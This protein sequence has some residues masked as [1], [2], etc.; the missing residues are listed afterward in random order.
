MGSQRHQGDGGLGAG[1][2]LVPEPGAGHRVLLEVAH[3]FGEPHDEFQ[4]LVGPVN[5]FARAEADVLVAGDQGP[6]AGGP[7]DHLAPEAVVVGVALLEAPAPGA[8]DADIHHLAEAVIVPD[9]EAVVALPVAVFLGR[10]EDNA[11]GDVGERHRTLLGLAGDRPVMRRQVGPRLGADAGV[12]VQAKE[13][14]LRPLAGE[15]DLETGVGL[16]NLRVADRQQLL[17]RVAVADK[18]HGHRPLAGQQHQRAAPLGDVFFQAFPAGP[19]QLIRRDVTQDD[20]VVIQQRVGI[21]RQREFGQA[22]AP[23]SLGIDDVQP[24]LV[25]DDAGRVHRL[26]ADQGG[27]QVVKLPA[28]LAIHQQHLRLVGGNRDDDG[29]GIVLGPG[30]LARV[31]G[32]GRFVL[33]GDGQCLGAGLLHAGGE[34]DESGAVGSVVGDLLDERSPFLGAG[35]VGVVQRDANLARGQV[36]DEHAGLDGRVGVLEHRGRRRADREHGEVGR[37]FAGAGADKVNRHAALAEF[38][39]LGA[40][41]GPPVV[42]AVGEDDDA[43]EFAVAAAALEGPQHRLFEVGEIPPRRRRVGRERLADRRPGPGDLG[44]RLGE[45]GDVEFMLR[46]DRRQQV[47]ARGVEDLRGDLPAGQRIDAGGDPVQA[48]RRCWRPAGLRL[49]DPAIQGGVVGQ[50]PDKAQAP[51]QFQFLGQAALG[52]GDVHAVGAVDRQQHLRG[53]RLAGGVGK[54]RLEAGDGQQGRDQREAQAEQNQGQSPGND[55]KFGAVEPQNEV[56]DEQQGNQQYAQLRAGG[57]IPE[58]GRQEQAGIG[59][60][61]FDAKHGR[62]ITPSF[63][64]DCTRGA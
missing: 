46:A 58:P 49:A 21:L 22:H 44:G 38:P 13:A 6:V 31:A 50:V 3:F 42:L 36:I 32:A 16:E 10:V 20:A 53:N 52:V 56:G 34:G 55:A 24:G 14:G 40:G 15:G 9:H 2:G 11:R 28:D 57:E 25:E 59:G 7:A 45:V 23:G 5:R 27:L 54:R 12:G 37:R 1:P 62:R 39:G 26:V 63:Q 19:G 61:Q 35:R 8:V 51:G 30:V 29:A 4:L 41:A 17:E 33:G 18:L 48:F 47:A 60:W 64:G 43:E